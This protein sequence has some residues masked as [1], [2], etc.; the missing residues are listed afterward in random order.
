MKIKLF[1]D[2]A[3]KQGILE[4]YQNPNIDGFTTNPTL[5]RKAGVTNYVSFSKEILEAVPDKPIS[6]E[7]FADEFKEM[8]QQA[9]EISNWGENVYVKIPVM[10]TKMDPSYDLIRNLSRKDVKLNITAIMTLEQVRLVSEA[11]LGGPSCYVS[12]FAGRIAD[13]G[14]DPV[15]LMQKA[16]D[17]LN[18]APNAELLWASP[19]EVFNVYQAESIGC[20]IITATNDI[21][22]KL[23]LKAKNLTDYSQETVQM[24]YNDAQASGF[25]L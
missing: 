17:I 20:H 25:K 7:V 24:F 11:V 15:P 14:V 22:K 23:N 18:T 21:L 5:M 4:M 1:A 2:G 16:L 10:N 12:V 8:E 13:T 9:L 6:F 19:R 3:D